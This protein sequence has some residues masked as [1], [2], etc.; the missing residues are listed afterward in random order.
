[1]S[2]NLSSEG[3]LEFRWLSLLS[4]LSLIFFV[5]ASVGA[6]FIQRLRYVF[7]LNPS[8]L[9]VVYVCE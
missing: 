1:M 5:L 6:V 4:S 9:Q 3:L 7:V 2:S 8:S